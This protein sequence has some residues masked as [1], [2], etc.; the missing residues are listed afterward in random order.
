MFVHDFTKREVSWLVCTRNAW[1]GDICQVVQCSY[2]P[3]RW[4]DVLVSCTDSKRKRAVSRKTRHRQ[5]QA[6]LRKGVDL[7]RLSVRRTPRTW[8]R[9][10][11]LRRLLFRGSHS[12]AKNAKIT[13]PS[14]KIPA[15]YTVY[16]TRNTH[17]AEL[18][19]RTSVFAVCLV[20][21]KLRFLCSQSMCAG[22]QTSLTM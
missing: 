4:W 18:A 19:P 5:Q 16:F 17:C 6:E 22:N 11:N 2:G 10:T 3:T 15:S 14:E 8:V 12:T 9:V 7:R 21:P 13:P 20:F 1:N